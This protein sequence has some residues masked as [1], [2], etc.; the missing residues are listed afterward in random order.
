MITRPVTLANDRQLQHGTHVLGLFLVVWGGMAGGIMLSTLLSGGGPHGFAGAMVPLFLVAGFAAFFVGLYMVLVR[1]EVC[2]DATRACIEERKSFLG[3]TSVTPFARQLFDRVELTVAT[4][5]KGAKSYR[6]ALLG[7]GDRAV[8]L[9]DFPERNEALTAGMRAARAAGFAF[10]ERRAAGLP[11]RL[12][13]ADLARVPAEASPE[14]RP[15]WRRPSAIA[16]VAANLVPVLG[17]VVWD[18]HLLPVMLLFWMENV[19]IGLYTIVRILLARGEQESGPAQ[20]APLAALAGRFFLAAF[21]TVHYGVFCLVHGGFIVAMFA[22]DQPGAA[23]PLKLAELPQIA[24]DFALRH[25]LLLGAIALVASHGV[26]FYTH[27]LKPRV[28]EDANAGKFMVEPYKR[29]VILHLV[30]LVGAF[31]ASAFGSSAPLLVL[32]IALKIVVDLISHL[33][34]H[35]VSYER[36]MRDFMAEHGH[37]FVRP[38]EPAA[39]PVPARADSAAPAIGEDRNDQPLAHYLGAW[40][41]GPE[42]AVPPGWIA[43]AE[44][45]DAGGK[46]KVKLWSQAERGLAEEGEFDA[47]VRG[48]AGRVE[49]LEVRQQGDGRVRIARFTG[50]DAGAGRIDLN[51]IQHPEGNPKAMQAKSL[52]LQRA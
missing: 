44:F 7:A 38:I 11:L 35:A 15:W 26:S 8:A 20:P 13:P 27:F 46:L 16:L 4:S 51:E 9:G 17:V 24:F 33:R 32:L 22:H 6:I 12:T 21:F 10:E 29:V 52:S 19:V 47:A 36:V 49:F 48:G 5:D 40:R 2:F 23:Q 45:R 14:E 31:A 3:S 39:A 50:S 1:K 30:I 28:Y 18:W 34:E 43:R 37:R 42:T 41:A 25:G